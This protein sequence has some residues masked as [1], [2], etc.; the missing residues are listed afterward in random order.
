M[1]LYGHELGEEIDPLSAGLKFGVRMAK[2]GGF[3]G[4]DAL[5]RIEAQ[6]PA[7]TLRGFVVE[8]RRPARQGYPV[9]AAG[10]AVGE[11]TSGSPSPTLEVPIACA[12]VAREVPETAPLEVE[13]R[14]Q[15]SPL[16]AV[17]LPFY[18]RAR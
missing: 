1:P 14:G 4:R 17:P 7:R 16:R 13:I 15:R 2:P 8:G 18:S 12:Y 11:V 5:A 6:G 9:L 3:I 10:R